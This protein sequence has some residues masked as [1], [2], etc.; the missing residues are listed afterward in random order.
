MARMGI[1]YFAQYHGRLWNR[2]QFTIVV[3]AEHAARVVPA[4]AN[5]HALSRY[6]F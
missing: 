4:I 2:T 3:S 6:S 5:I 1:P